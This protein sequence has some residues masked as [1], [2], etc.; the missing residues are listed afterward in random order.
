MSDLSEE[1][2]A[3]PELPEASSEED[4]EDEDEEE[5][6]GLLDL[7]ESPCSPTC[8][9]MWVSVDSSAA[10]DDVCL[11]REEW[12]N[13]TPGE[14]IVTSGLKSSNSNFWGG[15]T[16]TQLALMLM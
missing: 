7:Y 8:D 1:I 5:S 15:W 11:M 2:S 10:S 3:P 4:E 16:G 12:R 14:E 6:K 13:V 9:S